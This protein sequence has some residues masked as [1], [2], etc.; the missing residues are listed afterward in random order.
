MREAYSHEVISHGFW[1]GTAPVLEAAFYAYAVP[2]PAA[3]DAAR[4]GP[5]GAFY[6][7][8]LKE[9]IL[10][11]EAARAAASPDAAITTFLESTY[12]QAALL[13]GW[14]RAALERDG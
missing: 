8:D 9:F 12:E 11:Y 2:E 4:I 13:A 3:L 10:P 1:P 6:H 14:D 5:D 7:P